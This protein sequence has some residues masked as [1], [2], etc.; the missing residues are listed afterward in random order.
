MGN[1]WVIAFATGFL[2]SDEARYIN[3]VLL[4]VDIG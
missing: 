2:D 4:P 3:G 1:A